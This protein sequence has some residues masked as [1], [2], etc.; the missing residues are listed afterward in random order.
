MQRRRAE[1]VLDARAGLGEGPIWDARTSELLWV[2]IMAGLVHRFDPATATDVA[3]DVGQPVGAVVPR[4]TGGYVLA[5]RDGFAVAKTLADG[6]RLIAPI[7]LDRPELRMN[8]G[9]CDSS[10]RFWA[11]TMH[12]DE[13][14]GAGS[15]YRLTSDGSVE[16]MLDNVTVSNGIGWS[17]DDTVMYYAD[18]PTLGI[19][20]FDYDAASGTISNRRRIVT[21]EEGS[22]SPDGLTVDEDGCIWIA[23]W[24][25]WA[26]R[27]YSPAGTL[28]GVVDVPAARVTKPAFGGEP[29]DELYITTAAPDAP[30]P[31][32]PHA[33]GI[34]VVHPGARGL[35]AHAYAG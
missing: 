31:E 34:F 28:E 26:V 20:A 1:L 16:T 4:A 6:M 19:D 15:L 29:L 35:P 30:D 2:D 25:G 12:V 33:G 3:V 23:L 17:P 22:G 8:D 5:V 9:A 10:G 14:P 11:G 13:V 21:I 27:R 32:Q 7:D 18:T 24:D